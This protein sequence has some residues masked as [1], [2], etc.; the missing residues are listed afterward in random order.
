[1]KPDL[2]NAAIAELL[3]K[4]AG[5]QE[6]IRQ[7]VAEMAGAGAARGYDYIAVTDH[8]K[9][10]KIAGGIDEAALARQGAEIAAANESMSLGGG[11][12]RV[13]RSSR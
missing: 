8:S 5:R 7:P 3:A 12:L 11:K 1:M 9:G 4:V 6:G 2:S 13:L 10:L